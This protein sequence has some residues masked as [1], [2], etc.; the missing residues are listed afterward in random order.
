MLSRSEA[1]N[2]LLDVFEALVV[3][4]DSRRSSETVGR[5]ARGDDIFTGDGML[6]MLL[7]DVDRSRDLGTLSFFLNIDG[8]DP[9]RGY[10]LGEGGYA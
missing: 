8:N 5:S 6:M 4:W 10:S 9:D 1:L 7:L 3:F 2:L